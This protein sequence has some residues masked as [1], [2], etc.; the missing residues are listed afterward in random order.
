MKCRFCHNQKNL[1]IF[2]SINENIPMFICSNCGCHNQQNNTIFNYDDGNSYWSNYKDPDGNVKD[3]SSKVER[4]FKIKNWYGDI[5]RYIN[6][7]KD[8]KVLDVGCGLGYLLSVLKTKFKFGIEPSSFACNYINEN[9]KDIKI[10]NNNFENIVNINDNF[11]VIIAYH[12]IEHLSEPEKFIKLLKSKLKKGGV[13]IIGTPLIGT[14]LSNYFGKYY[15]LYNKSHEILFNLK[16][17]DKLMRKNNFKVF[18]IEKPFFKTDYFNLKNII[19]LFYKNKISPP[20]Y[21]S[22]VTLYARNL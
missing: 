3:I 6:S 4:E 20:Y 2:T 7:L 8:I 11:D 1:K 16:S 10:F 13:L 9:F 17:I 22:I 5:P 14:L 21:G 19:R 12:V 15:R 18:K